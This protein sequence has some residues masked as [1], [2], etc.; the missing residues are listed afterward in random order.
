MYEAYKVLS[1]QLIILS[2]QAGIGYYF[3]N[4]PC[5]NLSL[6]NAI[7]FNHTVLLDSFKLE[8]CK[9]WVIVGPVV[10][11]TGMLYCI[12][13]QLQSLDDSW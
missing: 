7:V 8:S 9:L 5:P 4:S 1:G 13:F 6:C 3:L 12:A 2:V 11:P 10:K